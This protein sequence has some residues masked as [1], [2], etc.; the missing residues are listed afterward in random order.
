MKKKEDRLRPGEHGIAK[1]YRSTTRS[2]PFDFL[3]PF[4]LFLS[5]F[6]P[7]RFLIWSKPSWE[8]WAVLELGPKELEKRKDSKLP[9]RTRAHAHWTSSQRDGKKIYSISK[10][11]GSQRSCGRNRPKPSGNRASFSSTIFFYSPTSSRRVSFINAEL[12]QRSSHCLSRDEQ[13][14]PVRAEESSLFLQVVLTN[15][16]EEKAN[17]PS[18]SKQGGKG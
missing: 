14:L 1:R 11:N 9:E 3:R 10:G 4:F 17:L 2:A 16:Q 15:Q 5:I 6:F 8:W 13:T 7:G 18:S 12:D